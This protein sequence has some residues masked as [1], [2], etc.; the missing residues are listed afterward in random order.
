MHLHI[1]FVRLANSCV[2]RCRILSR[3][4]CDLQTNP[5][6]YQAWANMQEG[7]YQMDMN[8][9]SSQ[10][11]RAGPQRCSICE[12]LPYA[13]TLWCRTTKFVWHMWG[14]IF[15]ESQPLNFYFSDF[16]GISWPILTTFFNISYHKWSPVIL[17]KS[18]SPHLNCTRCQHLL[19]VSAGKYR[20]FEHVTI[21][22]YKSTSK[23]VGIRENL[24]NWRALWT[25]PLELGPI[26]K[27]GLTYYLPDHV[28]FSARW[29]RCLA[30][31]ITS[32]FQ[33]VRLR[34]TASCR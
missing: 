25:R 26:P 17:L 32:F 7:I 11:Q 34:S 16:F 4:I 29:R 3:W 13:Y 5:I 21:S 9:Q 30:R 18:T 12:I 8:S 1:A 2:R 24:K 22:L 33:P 28:L 10:F 19:C 23:G 6:D 31:F 27:G 14:G 15:R 20:V